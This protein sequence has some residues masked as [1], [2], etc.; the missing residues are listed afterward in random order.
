MVAERFLH[1]E[2]CGDPFPHPE[3]VD[4][5][6]FLFVPTGDKTAADDPSGI[7]LT[8]DGRA[9]DIPVRGRGITFD[10]DHFVHYPML[11]PAEK[12]RNTFRI[13]IRNRVLALEQRQTGKVG[14]DVVGKPAHGFRGR[15]FVSGDSAIDA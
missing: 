13:E 14:S 3:T 11:T 8:E 6:V 4:T 12:G 5:S 15:L 10:I 7:A 9:V 1:I 2:K